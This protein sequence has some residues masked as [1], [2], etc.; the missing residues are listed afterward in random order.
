[1]P[2]KVAR[3]G[4]CGLAHRAYDP[5]VRR[6]PETLHEIRVPSEVLARWALETPVVAQEATAAALTFLVAVEHAGASLL[7]V[8]SILRSE[9]AVVDPDGF[10]R[11]PRGAMEHFRLRGLG[12]RT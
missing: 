9:Q 4:T 2:G 6:L 12:G 7:P 3:P 11:L 1:M 10:L 5:P 8:P